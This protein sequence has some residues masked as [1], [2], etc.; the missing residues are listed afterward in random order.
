MMRRLIVAAVGVAAFAKTGGAQTRATITDSRV[1]VE[2]W[3][4]APDTVIAHTIGSAGKHRTEYAGGRNP[5][6]PFG[7]K[8]GSV[9]LMMVADSVMTLDFVDSSTKTY[10]E[11]KPGGMMKGALDM[12]KSLGAGLKAKLSADSSSVDSLGDGGI[13][14]GHR[15]VHFRTH[16]GAVMA[17][18]IFGDSIRVGLHDT[19]DTYVAPDLKDPADSAASNRVADE[20]KVGL[21]GMFP[22]DMTDAFAALSVGTKRISNAGVPLKTVNTITTN[23]IG[24]TTTQRTTTEVLKYER[25]VVPDS[26]F[27]IPAG[28]KKV[29]FR[30][31]LPAIPRDSTL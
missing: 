13:I 24:R 10:T 7:G 6:F 16:F 28:Y 23:A 17:L 14:A 18:S 19:I 29:E 20:M 12:F 8:A 15:T 4:A 27:Q 30:I 3:G 1:I 22:F 25:A 2:R 11:L 9:E 31:P 26:T 5:S 21:K